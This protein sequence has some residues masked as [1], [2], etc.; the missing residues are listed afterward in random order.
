MQIS[1][2]TKYK[3]ADAIIIPVFS[4][5]KGCATDL[6]PEDLRKEI[7]PIVKA[8][9]SGKKDEIEVTHLIYKKKPLSIYFVG[10]GVEKDNCSYSFKV[11]GGK[12]ANAIKDHKYPKVAIF[13]N[14]G[15]DSKEFLFFFTLGFLMGNYKF[16]YYYADK[17]KK[18]HHYK[19]IQIIRAANEFSK[20]RKKELEAI[21]KAI[22]YTRDLVNTPP[23]EMTPT[24]LAREAKAVAKLAPKQ[25]KVTVF[26]DKKLAKHKMGLILGV[27]AGSDE[28][29]RMIFLEYKKKPKNSKPILIAGKG[30]TFDAGGL[31]IKPTNYIEDMKSD[32][33][34]AASV[35]GLMRILATLKPDLHVIGIISSAENLLGAKAMRPGDILK[36]YNGKTVEITNTDAEGR[37]VLGDALSY[38]TEKYKPLF[39]LDMATLT[40]ACIAALSYETSGV[41]TN[42]EKLF[43]KLQ[44]ASERSAEFVWPLPLT[45]TFQEKVSG[46]ISDYKN[47]T[48]GISAGASMGGAFLEK[49]INGYPWLHMDIAGTSWTPEKT[50]LS[51]KG[52]TG[53]PVHTIWEMVKQYC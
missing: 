41:V 35:L 51:P 8:R 11:A 30:I 23:N 46:D 49:F 17:K 27:G 13:P 21:A 28:E 5:Q 39:V 4:K 14:H 18:Q 7:K 24:Q 2:L 29:S 53:T 12:T 44:T 36:A 1:D 52:A 47:W 43:K 3:Q 33:A 50:P 38:S 19:E 45:K 32:M 31:N 16:D 10:L 37:L 34:G 48:A 15:A 25:I 40:G 22:Y 42:N 9:V 6:L 20:E 26:D